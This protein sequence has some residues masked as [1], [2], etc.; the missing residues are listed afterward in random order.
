MKA[1]RLP[2]VGF[3]PEYGYAFVLDPAHVIRGG[4]L[5][6]DF[7]SGQ[8]NDLLATREVTLARLPT[9]SS[10]WTNFFICGSRYVNALLWQ[11]RWSEEQFRWRRKPFSTAQQ[12]CRSEYINRLVQWYRRAILG[13]HHAKY[14]ARLPDGYYSKAACI[15]S[16]RLSNCGNISWASDI[17][18][19]LSSFPIPV[20]CTVSSLES[21]D[22]IDDLI[23]AIMLSCE[24]SMQGELNRAER[25]YLL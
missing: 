19:V 16:P 15:S 2:K 6:P 12:R 8:T 21:Q 4:H 9:D 20:P 1:G 17:R 7:E 23:S 18:A 14:W 3:V 5:I 24:S 22:G 11:C 10:D 25:T 13:L